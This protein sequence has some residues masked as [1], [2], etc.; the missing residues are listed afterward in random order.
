M[1]EIVRKKLKELK[2]IRINKLKVQAGVEIELG[3]I[4]LKVMT[5]RIKEEPEEL[6]I[7]MVE[8]ETEDKI[9]A[10]KQREKQQEKEQKE[11]KYQK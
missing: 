4:K 7:K 9:E 8:I 6:Q 1:E 10:L 3:K 2:I 11:W 5:E